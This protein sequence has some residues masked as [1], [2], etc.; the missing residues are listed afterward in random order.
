MYALVLVSFSGRGFFSIKQK[1][2]FNTIEKRK[3]R[4]GNEASC[5][6]IYLYELPLPPSDYE[7]LSMFLCTGDSGQYSSADASLVPAWNKVCIEAK[8][9][10]GDEMEGL[11]IYFNKQSGALISLPNSGC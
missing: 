7:P 4:P 3:K 1:L 6:S 9:C 11:T 8:E 5:S 10:D 2:V